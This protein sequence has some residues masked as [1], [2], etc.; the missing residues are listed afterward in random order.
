[1]KNVPL[2]NDP[3]CM[4]K[5]YP[6]NAITNKYKNF[7]QML[8]DL[9]QPFPL[10]WGMKILQKLIGTNCSYFTQTCEHMGLQ[11]F[12]DSASPWLNNVV[13]ISSNLFCESCKTNKSVAPSIAAFYT[14]FLYLYLFESKV[15]LILQIICIFY[16]EWN[17]SWDNSILYKVM[18]K[19]FCL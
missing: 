14:F 5:C 6:I 18:V 4:D 3:L 19:W 2:E 17:R 1:M 16:L 10:T 12:F 8:K 13:F 15:V 9:L 7:K 11:Y